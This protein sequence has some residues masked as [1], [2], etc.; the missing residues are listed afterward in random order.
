MHNCE[1][2]RTKVTI[3]ITDLSVFLDN[4]MLYN[5]SLQKNSNVTCLVYI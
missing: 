4:R 3:A 1:R 2:L 5:F